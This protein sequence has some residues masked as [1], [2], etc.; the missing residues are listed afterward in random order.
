MNS[1]SDSDAQAS[2]TT[3]QAFALTDLLASLGFGLAGLSKAGFVLSAPREVIDAMRA[4][5]HPQA[6]AVVAYLQAHQLQYRSPD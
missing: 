5:G 2:I 1:T 4:S 3:A 6:P